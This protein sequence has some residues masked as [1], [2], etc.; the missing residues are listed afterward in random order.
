MKLAETLRL[1]GSG[2]MDGGIDRP[3]SLS[4]GGFNHRHAL[5]DVELQNVVEAIE[6]AAQRRAPGHL[7][8]L[9]L[10]EMPPDG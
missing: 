7:D 10:A 2:R 5:L 1:R 6:G 8:D 3:D 4:L 9:R